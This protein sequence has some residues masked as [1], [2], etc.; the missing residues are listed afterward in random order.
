RWIYY[1]SGTTGGAK[2]ARHTDGSVIAA[3]RGAIGRHRK[4]PSDVSA[5]AWPFPHVGGVSML[6]SVLI[7]GGRLVL[8][9]HFDP[10]TTP[11]RMAAHGTTVLG[12][13]TPFFKAYV[14]A[15]RRYGERPLFPALRVC[16]A[17]GAAVPG[18]VSREV[19]EVLGVPGIV[20]AWGLTE[21]PVAASQTP[22]DPD[23]G[24]NVGLPT[25]GVRVRVVDGELRLKGPQCF[26]GYVDASLDAEGFD[27][28]GWFRTGDLGTVDTGGRIRITG[29]LKDVII[30]NAE[31]ISARDVE[32]A[33]LSHPAIADAA[34]I[35]VPDPRTGER[36]CAVVVARPGGREPTLDGLAEHC[37]AAGLARFKAPERLVVLDQLPRNPMGKVLKNE[38]RS[39][40]AEP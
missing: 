15:Q 18:S 35:G 40:L 28:D 8:Y 17:G 37:R 20:D 32:E 31:N 21:F 25:P 38:L 27:E 1:T 14:A 23:I 7:A 12:S 22:E 16:V 13:A 39:A 29:R 11:M 2:G 4:V 26:L 6:A 10:E 3:A 34:V 9:D 30:R 33:L 36:V 5:I 24:T 19:A